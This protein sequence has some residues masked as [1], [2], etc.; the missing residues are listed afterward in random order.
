MDGEGTTD[1][2]MDGEGKTDGWMIDG[3][4]DGRKCAVLHLQVN[5]PCVDT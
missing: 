2:W 3:Q 4:T 1:G 5:Q